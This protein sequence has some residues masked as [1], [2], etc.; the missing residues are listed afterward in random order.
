LKRLNSEKEMKG[1]A[2]IPAVFFAHKPG[3][4]RA[5]NG[6]ANERPRRLETVGARLFGGAP[7]TIGEACLCFGFQKAAA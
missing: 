4:S 5:Q 2:K 1:V 7:A 3:V 6:S